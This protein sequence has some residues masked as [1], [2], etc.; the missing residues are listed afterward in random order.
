[1]LLSILAPGA[2]L[3]QVAVDRLLASKKAQAASS[4]KQQL[5]TDPKPM[6]C[7]LNTMSTIVH[8][9]GFRAICMHADPF[10]CTAVWFLERGTGIEWHMLG[11]FAGCCSSVHQYS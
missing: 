1:M 8:Q 4:K 6:G 7:F 5:H 9:S 3:I 2:Q 10:G 11:W